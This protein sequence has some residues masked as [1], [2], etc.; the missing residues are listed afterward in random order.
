MATAWAA[1]SLVLW[2]VGWIDID[3]D[4]TWTYMAIAGA[5]FVLQVDCPDLAMGRHIQF[6][7]L[8]LEAFRKMA[9]LHIAALCTGLAERLIKESVTYAVS[10]RQGGTLIAD[11]QLASDM[12]WLA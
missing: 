8:S 6:A 7:G 10:T 4:S 1:V 2:A 5:G 9:R 11:F 3:D 12:N